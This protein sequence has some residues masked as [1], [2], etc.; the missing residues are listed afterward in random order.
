LGVHILAR[1]LA[2]LRKKA[3]KDDNF[4]ASI[5]T[6][7]LVARTLAACLKVDPR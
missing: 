2:S 5:L 4:H 7:R 1:K 6:D 3:K